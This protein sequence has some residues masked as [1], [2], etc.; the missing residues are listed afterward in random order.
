MMQNILIVITENANTISYA[1]IAALF[2]LSVL[3]AIKN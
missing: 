2:T 3:Y 1:I